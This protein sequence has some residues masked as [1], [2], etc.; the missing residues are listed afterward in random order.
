MVTKFKSTQ[1]VFTI[2]ASRANTGDP[3]GMARSV[4]GCVFHR[5]LRAGVDLDKGGSLEAGAG[6]SPSL[7]VPAKASVTPRVVGRTQAY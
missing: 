1:S 6:L 3:H 4:L 5:T 2:H 7:A